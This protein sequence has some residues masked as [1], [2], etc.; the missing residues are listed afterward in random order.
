MKRN[1]ALLA[2]A[3]VVLLNCAGEASAQLFGQR[4]LG[5][6]LS[7]RSS[8]SARTSSASRQRQGQQ[9]SGRLLTESLFTDVGSF[10]ENARYVRENRQATDFV[11]ADSAETRGFVGTQQA[12]D[13]GG[14]A[15]ITSAVDDFQLEL[16]PDANATAEPVISARTGMYPPRLHVSFDFRPRPMGEI[17][18]EL[19]D[20]L[21]SILSLDDSSSIEVS[22]EGDVAIL[23]GEVA[24]ERD[25]RMAGLLVRFEP[26]IADSRNELT[27]KPPAAK[28]APA[29]GTVDH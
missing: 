28:V 4:N 10:K 20:R 26:G 15:E 14:E 2:F 19:A 11:G 13:L 27:V 16:S 12:T 9:S 6:S 3:V 22:V 23:R 1:P 29:P 7:R 25:R 24:S 17:S 5:S 21:E 18:T 8:A